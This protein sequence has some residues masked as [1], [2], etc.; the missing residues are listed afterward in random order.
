MD[1]VFLEQ[2]L[3]GL[4][5]RSFSEAGP[6]ER[7]N[8]I[9]ECVKPHVHDLR[10]VAGNRNTPRHLLFDAR[11]TEVLKPFLH[12]INS[13]LPAPFGHNG[14]L[15]AEVLQ[16]PILIF[17]EFEKIVLLFYLDKVHRR[18]I[19]ALA[20]HEVALFDER[21]I[22]DA[23][24]P[25]VLLLVNVARFVTTPP[26]LLRGR[27][28]PRVGR[29]DERIVRKIECAFQ[30]LELSRKVVYILLRVAPLV[31]RFLKYFLS[32]LVGTRIEEDVVAEEPPV[33]R[34]NVGLH[35][36]KRETD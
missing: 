6:T 31:F 19:R 17:A 20:V 4:A 27:D 33:A 11:N 36:L 23:V 10:I 9:G 7:R 8:V 25:L 24:E 1:P 16:Q 26:K 15:R 21:F 32:V 3:F 18:V 34:D 28:M 14:A 2:T 5:L 22:A 29:A 35:H 12:E 30:L 13:F